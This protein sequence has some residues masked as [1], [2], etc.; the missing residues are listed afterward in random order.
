MIHRDKTIILLGECHKCGETITSLDDPCDLLGQ[1]YHASCA[2]CVVCGQS[3]KNKHFYIENQLYCEEDFLVK[4]FFFIK[5]R[6]NS[7]DLILEIGFC[8][9]IDL[10]CC[11]SSIDY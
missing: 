8:F 10:L 3:V 7:F 11:L 4:S 6:E 5:R 9:T 1:I 2:V